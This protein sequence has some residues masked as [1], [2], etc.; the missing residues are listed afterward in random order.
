MGSAQAA[1]PEVCIDAHVSGEGWQGEVCNSPGEY[2]YAGTVGENRAI[3]ALRV[4]A[5]GMGS[6]CLNAHLRNRG[7]VGER[8]FV[9]NA[10]PIFIGT[11]G[12]NRPMEALTMSVSNG[13]IM[14]AAHVQ[15]RGWQPWKANNFLY[16]GTEGS[17]LNMEAIAV[18]PNTW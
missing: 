5:P 12:E 2:G 4:R 3:E 9:A 11:T 6:V 14:G 13:S 17:A 18:L 1:T 16:F 15:S 7:W 10:H 8:C